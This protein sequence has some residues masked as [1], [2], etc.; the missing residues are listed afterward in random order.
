MSSLLRQI[1]CCIPA[2]KEDKLD[3]AKQQIATGIS[4]RN[5]SAEAIAR[6]RGQS[7]S[8]MARTVPTDE[9]PSTR[10][11]TPSTVADLQAWHRPDRYPQRHDRRHISGDFD[12]TADGEQNCDQRFA[13]LKRGAPTLA[14]VKAEFPGPKAGVFFVEKNDINQSSVNVFGHRHRAQQP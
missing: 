4:R 1:F 10:P 12:S 8:P 9:R 13:G 7:C 14:P 6:P 11:L 5:D 2:F 3:L